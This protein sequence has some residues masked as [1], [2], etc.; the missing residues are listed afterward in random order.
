MTWL[1]V[2][3][4]VLIILYG[5]LGYFTGV[6]RR[7]IGLISLYVGFLAAAGMGLQAGNLLQQSTTLDTPDARIYGFFGILFIVLVLIDGAAQLANNQI[8]IEAIVWNGM[9]GVL[10]EVLTEV[11]LAVLVV[12]E[13]EAAG[14]PSRGGQLAERHEEDYDAVGRTAARVTRVTHHE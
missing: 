13:L 4:I 1:D 14:D 5:V 10:V 12:Y 8:R 6:L 2:L 7:A 9:S 3:P 11:L